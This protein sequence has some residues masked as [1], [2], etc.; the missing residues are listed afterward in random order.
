[1]MG[2]SAPTSMLIPTYMPPAPNPGNGGCYG[3]GQLGHY[4][5][6]CPQRGCSA[7]QRRLQP[8]QTQP[9]QQPQT[10]QIPQPP[11]LLLAGQLADPR[12]GGRNF[13]LLYEYR[14]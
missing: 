9:S 2:Y 5:R 11:P 4:K 10:Q 3:C 14:L 12:I 1:M 7:G 8:A 13:H 6:D